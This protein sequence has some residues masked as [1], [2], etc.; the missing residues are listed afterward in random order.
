[1]KIYII[2][3]ILVVLEDGYYNEDAKQTLYKRKTEWFETIETAFV[4]YIKAAKYIRK[5]LEKE[6]EQFGNA[7]SE[8]DMKKWDTFFIGFHHGC[9]VN[10][11][12]NLLISAYCNSNN[13]IPPNKFVRY[14]IKTISL[15]NELLDEREEILKEKSKTN[16]LDVFGF[17]P[18]YERP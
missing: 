8:E 7:F 11:E 10:Y 3:K 5:L 17:T 12:T 9:Q 16:L 4:S 15:D 6:N 13:I 14:E 2:T 18:K 1:M